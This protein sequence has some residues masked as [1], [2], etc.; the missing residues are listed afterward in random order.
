MVHRQKLQPAEREQ[1]ALQVLR[2]PDS[3]Q[4]RQARILPNI[5]PLQALQ[6]VG[7]QRQAVELSCEESRYVRLFVLLQL[8]HECRSRTTRGAGTG[9]KLAVPQLQV[10]EG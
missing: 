4:Q 8:T 1:Q 10:G 5:Q 7:C 3:A 9:A 2:R 6:Q